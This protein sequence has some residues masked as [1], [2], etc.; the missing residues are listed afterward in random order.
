[1]QKEG[2]KQKLVIGKHYDT[3]CCKQDLLMDDK[4][5][6]ISLYNLQVS[7]IIY[8][9]SIKARMKN[10]IM[11][12][13]SRK[14]PYPSNEGQQYQSSDIFI[15]SMNLLICMENITH[16]CGVFTKNMWPYSKQKETSDKLKLRAFYT[17]VTD[18]YSSD[19]SR[20]WKM[21][22][23]G[24]IKNWRMLKITTECRSVEQKI[25]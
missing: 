6:W 10:F 16:F 13:P 22:K 17:K 2:R 11:I 5:T 15:D 25:F 4:T 18:Q 23:T 21:R 8:S 19:M 12:K 7:A 1:M 20:S 24:N 14:P 3:N 9:L